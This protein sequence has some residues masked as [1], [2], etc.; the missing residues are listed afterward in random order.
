VSTLSVFDPQERLT[1]KVDLKVIS[2]CEPDPGLLRLARVTVQQDSDIRDLF[3]LEHRTVNRA[4]LVE[5]LE[6]HFPTDE[7]IG[8][9]AGYLAD[10]FEQIGGGILL[11]SSETGRALAQL[12]DD[13]FYLPSPVPREDG[14]MATPQGPRLRPEIEATIF[15]W[16]AESHREVALLE[17]MQGRLH[18]TELVFEEGDRRLQALHHRGRKDIARQV[19]SALP[20]LLRNATGIARSFLSHFAFGPPPVGGSW[21]SLRVEVS[22]VNRRPVQDQTTANLRHD[23]LTSTLATTAT[24]WSRCLATALLTAA[25]KQEGP[26]T[27]DELQDVYRAGAFVLAEPGLAQALRK[28]GYEV[29]PA[30]G[31]TNVAVVLPGPVGFLEIPEEKL[32]TGT[33]EV[34][35]VWTLET[36]AEVVLWVEWQRCSVLSIKGDFTSGL[37]CEVI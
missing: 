15:H 9:V 19:Y 3:D 25:K 28:R 37:S 1:K 30:P 33:R 35:D 7:D 5:A 31:P 24:A 4:A 12:T 11:I 8:Q 13:D 29:L 16:T 27:L 6:Q 26:Y 14:G 32:G 36:A 10:E 23:V 20:T 21:V 34:H 17:K 18:Q 22:G 2:Q